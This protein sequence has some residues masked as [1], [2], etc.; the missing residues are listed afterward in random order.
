MQLIPYLKTDSEYIDDFLKLKIQWLEE[1]EM[2]N[3]LT[4]KATHPVISGRLSKL[5]QVSFYVS[6]STSN[7]EKSLNFHPLI[8]QFALLRTEEQGRIRSMRSPCSCGTMLSDTA[9]ALWLAY[10]LERWY[11]VVFP[12]ANT[13]ASQM[14]LDIG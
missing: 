13:L 7:S 3:A 10:T 1:E 9:A 11:P 4:Y 6:N 12:F 2:P 5:R 14:Q 8:L